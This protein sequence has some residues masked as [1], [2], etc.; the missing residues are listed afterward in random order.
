MS[1]TW[2][3]Q[4]KVKF[5][6]H[7]YLTAGEARS[8]DLSD[9]KKHVISKAAYEVDEAAHFANTVFYAKVQP[10]YLIRCQGAVVHDETKI[11]SPM[12]DVDTGATEGSYAADFVF[13][14]RWYTSIPVISTSVKR[15]D[16]HNAENFINAASEMAFKDEAQD[17]A[18]A[19]V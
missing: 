10:I 14:K 16:Y 11:V 13:L 9:P 8:W 4:F 7:A 17:E 6:D 2:C 1:S 18:A 15:G 3:A 19:T 12:K 5:F